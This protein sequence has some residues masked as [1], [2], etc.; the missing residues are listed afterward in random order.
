MSGTYAWNDLGGVSAEN[1][2][3][4]ENRD[5]EL[6]FGTVMV[7]A[8]EDILWCWKFYEMMLWFY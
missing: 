1:K 3:G 6:Q 2:S 7:Y 5:A 4:N 8:V